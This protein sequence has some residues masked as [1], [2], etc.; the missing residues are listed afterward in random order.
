MSNRRSLFLIFIL[1][2]SAC[3]SKFEYQVNENVVCHQAVRE[4]CGMTLFDCNDGIRYYCMQA[5]K[6]RKIVNE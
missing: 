2:I 5:V 4:N 1:F 6:V 3:D